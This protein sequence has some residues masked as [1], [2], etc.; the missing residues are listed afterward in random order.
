VPSGE[1]A[2]DRISLVWPTSLYSSTLSSSINQ[3]ASLLPKRQRTTY[4][5]CECG[6]DVV[7]GA[8]QG[9]VQF[10]LVGPTT[11]VVLL[12]VV[13]VVVVVVVVAVVAPLSGEC[14]LVV[15]SV[16]WEDCPDPVIDASIEEVNVGAGSCCPGLEGDVR[17]P[18][19]VASPC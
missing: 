16:G 4:G 17:P 2:T 8:G 12:A 18:P 15:C 14:S 5:I 9:P 11:V 13:A 1:M 6:A 19:G 3:A 7:V 10:A